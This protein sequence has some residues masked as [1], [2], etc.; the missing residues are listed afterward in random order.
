M[1]AAPYVRRDGELTEEALAAA[2]AEE[3][4]H[5][6]RPTLLV[7]GDRETEQRALRILAPHAGGRGGLDVLRASVPSVQIVDE[8]APGEWEL[9]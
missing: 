5:G 2:I 4:R 8:L 9:R 1:A 7:C 6:G 3:S